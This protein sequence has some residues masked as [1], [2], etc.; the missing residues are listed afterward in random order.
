MSE[1]ASKDELQLKPLAGSL[2]V[3]LDQW[4]QQRHLLGL[5][6]RWPKL[7]GKQLAEHSLPAYFLRDELWIYTRH[8]IWM[9]QL[10]FAKPELLAQINAFLQEYNGPQVSDLRW[11]LLPADFPSLPAAKPALPPAQVDP[12]EERQFQV[13]AE[14]IADPEVRQAFCRLWRG[15]QKKD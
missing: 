9:Q 2:N 5:T 11:T 13:M 7:V 14:A 3:L 10:S 15:M 4:G 1:Q 6:R 8:A 12:E